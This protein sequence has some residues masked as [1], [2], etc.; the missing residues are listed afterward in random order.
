[1]TRSD[2]D[3]AVA[4]TDPDGDLQ[5]AV[6][7]G[8]GVLTEPEAA[9]GLVWGGGAPAAL[10]ETLV[11]ARRLRWVQLP[12]AGVEE[13]ASLID[14]RPDL[15]WTCAKGIYGPAVAE[16]AV[17][18]LLALRRGLHMHARA[19]AWSPD[20]VSVPLVR[21]NGAVT[22]L[23]GGGIAVHVAQLLQP[24]GLRIRVVRRRAGETFG[25]PHERM[26]GEEQLREAISHS[27]ALII[28]LPLTPHTRGLIGEGELRLMARGAI[29]INVG[30]GPVLDHAVLQPLLDEGAVGALGL[31]VTDPEPLPPDNPLWTDRRCLITSHTSNPDAW[32][33]EQLASLV[34]ENVARFR[35]GDQLRGRVDVEAGY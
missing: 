4:G 21:S 25:A 19:H 30:R 35:N 24:L 31:D 9:S 6:E 11:Q 18:M 27:S 34:E 33:R 7:A 22:I 2:V 3:I 5:R 20:V 26:F 8:G 1:M 12:S 17:A 10:N 23:G 28:T 15:V 13:Q 32:R 14:G 16:H 29:V